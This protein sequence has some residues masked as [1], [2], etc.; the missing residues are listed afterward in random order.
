M[1][2]VASASLVKYNNPV[3]VSTT[4][5]GKGKGDKNGGASAKKVR[6]FLLRF[7]IFV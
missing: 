7:A 6:R 5:N 2:S 1:T 3:L 4:K